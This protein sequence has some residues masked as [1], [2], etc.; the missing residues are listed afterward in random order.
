[1]L[2]VFF[3]AFRMH[4][5]AS[6]KRSRAPSCDTFEGRSVLLQFGNFQEDRDFEACMSDGGLEA[7]GAC[8]DS[9]DEVV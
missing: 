1:M 8:E 4:A 9:F 3:V 6:V 7:L 2:N 5:H